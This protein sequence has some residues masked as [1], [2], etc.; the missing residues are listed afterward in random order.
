[1]VFPVNV[2]VKSL[3]GLSRFF[4]SRHNHASRRGFLEIVINSS[5]LGNSQR[6]PQ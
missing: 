1:M 6:Q 2:E 4:K 3:K 5:L